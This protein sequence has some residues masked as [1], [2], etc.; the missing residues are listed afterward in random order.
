MEMELVLE[1]RM[2]WGGAI[3]TTF[4]AHGFR[5]GIKAIIP[6]LLLQRKLSSLELGTV[7]RKPHI[8]QHVAQLQ[9]LIG[10]ES[11]AAGWHPAKKPQT[12]S[13][14]WKMLRLST[15]SSG[16]ASTT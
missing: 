10:Q 14:A 5:W 3:C 15:S 16:T 1:A 4:A 11:A 6:E 13:R 2:A 7:Y 9:L 8:L 12:L